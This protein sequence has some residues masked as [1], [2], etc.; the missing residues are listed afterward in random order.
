MLSTGAFNALLKTI[1]EP[2]AHVIFILATTEY[3]KV[4]ETIIS[5]CQCYAF[6]RILTN[7][8]ID[9]LKYI[10]LK[11]NIKISQEVL[12]LIAKY[13]NGGLRDAIGMLDK[14]SSYSNDITAQDFYDLRGVVDE[15]VII[16][17]VES[18]FINDVDLILK[19]IESLFMDGKNMT[20]FIND[21]LEYFTNEIVNDSKN[22]KY[23]DVIDILIDT[24][25]KLKKNS[26]QKII[27]EIGL[28]KIANSFTA[29]IISQ[30]IVRSSNVEIDTKV[31]KKNNFE[32]KNVSI[33]DKKSYEQCKTPVKE[34]QEEIQKMSIKH[35]I[36]KDQRI[37]NALALAN[38]DLL[39]NLKNFWSEISNYLYNKDFSTVASYLIDSTLRVA[40][41]KD[42]IIS[43]PYP[44]LLENMI[45]NLGQL[46]W[47]FKL[48]SGNLYHMVFILDEEWEKLRLEYVKNKKNGKIYNYIEEKITEDDIIISDSSTLEKQTDKVSSITE[49]MDLFGNDLVEIK[50]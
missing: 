24:L 28:L 40:G 33:V 4:P 48:I 21:L 16:K 38:K 49:A 41:D 19:M 29:E 6:E 25:E 17:L 15:S 35:G 8:I 34:K 23:Y 26:N 36:L 9:K 43:V 45:N 50:D 42:L 13:C 32:E 31:I 7:D 37:N 27:I 3:Y 1:E 30:E 39:S 2:P 12:E 47:L 18:L 22:Q 11:E 44:S 14:L 10:C 46:E 5:R 20:L